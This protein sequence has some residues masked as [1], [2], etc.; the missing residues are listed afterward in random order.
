MSGVIDFVKEN[1][2]LYKPGRQPEIVEVPKMK[3]IMV[4]GKGAPDPEKG[5]DED[6]SE[7]QKMFPVLYGL[8]Y[9]IKMSYKGEE[10][11]P[12]Y[13]NFKVPPPEALWWMADN[14]DFDIERPD[15]WRWTLML[16]VPDFVT[17]KIVQDFIEKLVV[18]KKSEDYKKARLEEY[19]EGLAVQVMHV[20]AYKE[21]GPTID[22]MHAF[23]K[24][25]GYTLHGKH[26]E[27]YYGDPRR[28]T[29]E[30]LKTV[31]RQPV[32]KK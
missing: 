19:Q 12:G 17:E 5:T 29:P 22:A 6:V 2:Q 30:K 10:Q 7:F 31:L 3:F 16:R 1:K 32:V 23:A 9:G 13:Q 18:K 26:H 15:K 8:A 21:E 27:I 11:L 4:D 25:Q 14:S 20:G 24:Q 28:T